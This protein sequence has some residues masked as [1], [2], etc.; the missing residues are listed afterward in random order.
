MPPTGW[1]FDAQAAFFWKQGKSARERT[2]AIASAS[3]GT[4]GEEGGEQEPGPGPGRLTSPAPNQPLLVGDVDRVP[5]PSG[6]RTKIL[7]PQENGLPLCVGE[8]EMSWR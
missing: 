3:A 8:M 5:L 1:P 6:R 7:A 2:G 4:G